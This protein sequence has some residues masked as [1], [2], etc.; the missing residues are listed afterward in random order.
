MNPFEQF[1]SIMSIPSKYLKPGRKTNYLQIIAQDEDWYLVK[2]Y[3]DW[4]YKIPPIKILTI[5]HNHEF[6]KKA[7]EL[8]RYTEKCSYCH[9]NAPKRFIA[10]KAIGNV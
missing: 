2:T 7:F 9:E 5:Y 1:L 8:E 4:I 6:N 3:N 10:I